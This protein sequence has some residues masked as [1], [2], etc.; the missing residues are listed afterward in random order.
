[1]KLPKGSKRKRSV[2]QRA[3][4]LSRCFS[5]DPGQNAVVCVKHFEV[6]NGE[7]D[8]SKGPCHD[9]FPGELRRHAAES[10]AEQKKELETKSREELLVLLLQRME[11]EKEFESTIAELERKAT[12]RPTNCITVAAIKNNDA[13]CRLL[14]GLDAWFCWVYEAHF[15]QRLREKRMRYVDQRLSHSS[16]EL[17]DQF[18]LTLFWLRHALPFRV[19]S[20]FVSCSESIVN[21]IVNTWVCE[22]VDVFGEHM[23]PSRETV[24]ATAPARFNG[25]PRTVLVLDATDLYLDKPSSIDAQ[26]NTWS[27]YKSANTAKILV[28]VT[29]S[30]FISYVSE[31]FGGSITDVELVQR[32]DFIAFLKDQMATGNIQAGDYVMVD[33][34]FDIEHLLQPLGLKVYMPPKKGRRPQVRTAPVVSSSLFFLLS[35]FFSAVSLQSVELTAGV[36][37]A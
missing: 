13:R 37:G 16:V 1:V 15:G 33:R 25:H 18:L 27:N 22:M 29:P 30:G 26:L 31:A 6:V 14:T 12:E 7:V 4:F 34:G 28:A 5:A 3:L 35:S 36:D 8:H 21:A 20:F 9:D 11:K 24:F 10:L 2:E 32:S 19:L 17:I 23:M